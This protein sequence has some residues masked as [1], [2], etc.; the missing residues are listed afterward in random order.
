MKHIVL[1]ATLLALN[2]ICLGSEGNRPFE[3]VLFVWI[4]KLSWSEMEGYSLT[5]VKRNTPFVFLGGEVLDEGKTGGSAFCLERGKEYVLTDGNYRSQLLRFVD[6]ATESTNSIASRVFGL[7]VPVLYFIHE[8]QTNRHVKAVS[9]SYVISADGVVYDVEN[10][11]TRKITL[12]LEVPKRL[13]DEECA[14]RYFLDTAHS[15]RTDAQR[16]MEGAR[17]GLVHLSSGPL[18]MAI[19]TNV[20]CYSASRGQTADDIRRMLKTGALSPFMEE[21][22]R[23]LETH[24]MPESSKWALVVK[25]ESNSKIVSI[26]EY[27]S[28]GDDE[29][30]HFHDNGCVD[31]ILYR[32]DDGGLIFYK[33]DE[34]GRVNWKIRFRNGRIVGFWSLK[35]GVYIQDKDDSLA[36]LLLEA[37]VNRWGEVR[38]GRGFKR[39]EGI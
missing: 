14:L 28:S 25:S 33:Y 6:P 20:V 17:R 32:S 27:L 36:R 15:E 1:L 19:G 23:E 8:E 5:L 24:P 11:T 13:S 10:G 29:W 4:D 16:R 26:I 18:K 31:T 37:E 21:T 2:V 38:C 34:A 12:P 9:R 22:L 35:G 39:P 7:G 30:T 3:D